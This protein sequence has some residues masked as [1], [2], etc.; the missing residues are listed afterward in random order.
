MLE[1]SRHKSSLDFR[2][3]SCYED[4][5]CYLPRPQSKLFAMINWLC[6]KIWM[7]SFSF[8]R[9]LL[10]NSDFDSRLELCFTAGRCTKKKREENINYQYEE[11]E[12]I[13]TAKILKF[14]FAG[15]NPKNEKVKNISQAL[16]FRSRLSPTIF[17]LLCGTIDR[18]FP[19]LLKSISS[20]INFSISKSKFFFG[21]AAKNMANRF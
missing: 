1:F 6:R 7:V 16:L 17:V 14:F 3:K 21:G 18:F 9:F 15:R 2:I 12:I 20:E 13:T 4:C 19:H 5:R 11:R 8:P 10:L